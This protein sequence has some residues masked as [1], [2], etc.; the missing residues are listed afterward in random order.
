MKIFGVNPFEPTL[1][2]ACSTS[3]IAIGFAIVGFCG[4]VGWGPLCG[5]GIV[6]GWCFTKE[7]VW[8]RLVERDPFWWPGGL[9]DATEYLIGAGACWLLYLGVKF[10]GG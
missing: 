5:L 10:W 3:H 7:A 2:Q 8:D 9:K 1:D 6:L 4:W